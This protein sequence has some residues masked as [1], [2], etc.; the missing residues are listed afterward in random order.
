MT[1]YQ[2]SYTDRNGSRGVVNLTA[3]TLQGAKAQATRLAPAMT[4]INIL[5]DGEPVVHREAWRNPNGAYGL[6]PWETV[7]LA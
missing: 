7:N 1:K 5:V 3:Q 6:N 4:T 2:A